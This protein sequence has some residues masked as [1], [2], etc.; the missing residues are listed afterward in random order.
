[1]ADEFN[2]SAFSGRNLT[3]LVAGIGAKLHGDF[4]GVSPREWSRKLCEQK[5]IK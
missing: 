3:E 4:F 2:K 5:P 1:M